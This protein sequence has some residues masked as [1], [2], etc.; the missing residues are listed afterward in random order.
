MLNINH[1][2]EDYFTLEGGGGGNEKKT[3][4]R[5][6]CLWSGLGPI[7]F[8]D[9]CMLPHKTRKM[10]TIPE[11]LLLSFSYTYSSCVK[12]LCYEYKKAC[13]KLQATC[14]HV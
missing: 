7:K 2:S 8:L 11:F 12:M 3:I 10:D 4:T 13:L 14:G 1:V 6:A 9:S 5:S